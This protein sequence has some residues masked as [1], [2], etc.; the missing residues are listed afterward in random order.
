M[1]TAK[2]RFHFAQPKFGHDI[3]SH[4]SLY[5]IFTQKY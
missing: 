3:F 4:I 1:L 5:N 2:M